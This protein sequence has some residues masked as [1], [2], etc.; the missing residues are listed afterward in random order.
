MTRPIWVDQPL[1][2]A[3]YG[4]VHRILADDGLGTLRS[5][6]HLPVHRRILSFYV[7]PMS[8][9]LE[10]TSKYINFDLLLRLQRNQDKFM[11]V[12]PDPR[13]T[14]GA[15]V[16]PAA[17]R[18]SVYPQWPVSFLATYRIVPSNDRRLLVEP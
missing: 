3:L 1:H 2:F 16:R 6:L 4:A 15:S 5:S 14:L 8:F 10:P 18:D 11:T 7:F 12:P 17:E 13:S 9:D